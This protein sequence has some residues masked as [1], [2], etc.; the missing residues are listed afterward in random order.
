MKTIVIG[1]GLSGVTTAYF[2]RRRGHE[3]TVI[4]QEEGP[5]RQTSF[6]NGALL[7][8]SM[9]DPWNAPGCWR[10]LLAALGRSDAAMQ[11]HLRALPALAGWGIDFLR[12][13]SAAAFARNTLGN[14][15][16]AVHS[17]QV[18]HSLRKQ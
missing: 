16:L 8:P 7:T 9:S 3:V 4:D 6:A 13:S 11:M 1:G 18:M 2:L 5:G 14:L 15:R 17:L 10:M 12:N